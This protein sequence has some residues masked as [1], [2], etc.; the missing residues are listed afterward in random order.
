MD[1]RLRS[2]RALAVDGTGL[3]LAVAYGIVREHGGRIAVES[4][5]GRGSRFSVHLPRERGE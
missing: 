1:A 2:G 4:E 3:G 5:P